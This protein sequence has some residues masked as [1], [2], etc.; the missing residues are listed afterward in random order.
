[1]HKN[2]F[3]ESGPAGRW[4]EL[5]RSPKPLSCYKGRD[6]RGRNWEGRRGVKGRTSRGRGDGKEEGKMGRERGVSG[7]EEAE[8]GE[9]MGKG[10][11]VWTWI[12]AQGP[13]VPSYATVRVK[14][15]LP[16]FVAE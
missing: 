16:R 13:R 4:G 10:G 14:R 1:L 15:K 9:R 12:F 6:G 8:G 7:R 3:G 11:E 5:W 2:A